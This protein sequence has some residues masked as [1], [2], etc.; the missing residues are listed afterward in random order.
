MRTP[1]RARSTLQSCQKMGSLFPGPNQHYR[2]R[3]ISYIGD[4]ENRPIATNLFFFFTSTRSSLKNVVNECQ[5]CVY[6]HEHNNYDASYII[7]ILGN[8]INSEPVAC[9][10]YVL[11]SCCVH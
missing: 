4:S 6:K 5:L 1:N 3:H 11:E 2:Y 8:K 9:V 7:I 10:L